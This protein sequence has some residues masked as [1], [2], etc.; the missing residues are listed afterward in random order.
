MSYYTFKIP[1]YRKSSKE[2][3]IFDTQNRTVGSLRRV[4]TNAFQKIID[5]IFS[6]DMF[7]NVESF[8]KKNDFSCKAQEYGLIRS[9]WEI[10]TNSSKYLLHNKTKIKTNPRMEFELNGKK[11]FIKKDFADRRVYFETDSKTIATFTYD[12][13]V[14]SKTIEADINT[15]NI[16]YLELICLYYVFILRD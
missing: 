8:D 16:H 13:I 5:T 6:N 3:E 14:G 2:I 7:I 10:T 11:H 1:M 12:K 15:D 9:E 4:Y